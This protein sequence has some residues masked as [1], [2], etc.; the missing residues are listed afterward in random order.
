MV[1][2]QNGL[3]AITDVE[4][5]SINLIK[6]TNTVKYERLASYNMPLTHIVFV[7]EDTSHEH[8]AGSEWQSDDAQHWHVCDAAG[9]PTPTEKMEAAAHTWDEGVVVT[10]ADHNNEGEKKLTCTVCGHV[11]IEK[12]P[13]VAHSWTEGTPANNSDEKVVTPLSCSCGKVGAKMAFKDFSSCTDEAITAESTS[14]K[15]NGDAANSITFKIVVSKAGTYR[16]DTFAKYSQ[17]NSGQ[18]LATAPYTVSVNGV[19]A[20]VSSGTYKELGM[21]SSSAAQFI[22]VPTMTLAEGENTIVIAQ[23]TG[24]YRL[25]FSDSIIVYEK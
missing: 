17:G 18:S 4:S 7:F 22:L 10:P 25:T 13:A 14:F 6:G 15:L 16:L 23:G 19:D 3:S 9:C 5:G 24:G 1:E 12:I 2:C 20:P 21:N 11:K 8:H